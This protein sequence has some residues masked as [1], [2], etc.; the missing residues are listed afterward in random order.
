MES[1]F[2]TSLRTFIS[3]SILLLLTRIL[4]KKQ[5]NHV[6]VFTYITGI[7]LGNIAGDMVVHKDIK[8]TDGI[9][10]LTLWSLLTL[11][12]EYISLKSV[13]VR[14]ILDG[15]PS[16]IIK[17]GKI[18]VDA[19]R[20]NKLNMDDLMMLMRLKDVFSIKE[21]EYAILEP[22]GQLSILKKEE[23][24]SVIKKDT[25][26]STKR[27]PY[28]PTELVVDGK[29]IKKNL[30]ELNINEDWLLEELKMKGHPHLSKIF[31]AELQPDGSIH[32]D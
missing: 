10:G 24:E 31:Y 21:V 12:I 28:L 6:T 29:I 1:I 7:A 26:I 15:E 11:I 17:Q 14:T 20:S 2:I 9:I 3:F 27:R 25:H 19:M 30:K 16:I 32:V 13:K 18:H 8:I 22:N 5:L 23:Y 4:G